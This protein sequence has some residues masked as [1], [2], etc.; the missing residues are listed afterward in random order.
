M[1]FLSLLLSFSLSSLSS[2]VRLSRIFVFFFL[3]LHLFL[4]FTPPPCF[5]I[6][7]QL[8]PPP[9]L[10]P[11]I[12]PSPPP[13]LSPTIPPSPPPLS[14][15]IPPSPTPLSP[16]IP[17]SPLLFLLQF[18]PF[19]YF[20]YISSFASSSSLSYTSLFSDLQRLWLFI[21][22]SRLCSILILYT[23]VHLWPLVYRF[24]PIDH[25]SGLQRD[26]VSNQ[27]AS[28]FSDYVCEIGWR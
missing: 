4:L 19:S 6:F 27:S 3:P 7:F 25:C 2:A 15:T 20:S 17:P 14:P 13:P 23:R 21:S 5:F 11:T 22:N 24:I 8:L 26:Y 28:R 9:H 1:T 18:F 10:S 16:T 12:F